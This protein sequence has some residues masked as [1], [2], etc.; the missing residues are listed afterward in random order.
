M[1]KPIVRGFV[2]LQSGAYRNDGNCSALLG[3][4]VRGL[5]RSER[6]DAGLPTAVRSTALCHVRSLYIMVNVPVRSNL[7]HKAL[8]HFV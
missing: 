4:I 8:A 6:A 1:S 7:W 5:E 3:V 2:H